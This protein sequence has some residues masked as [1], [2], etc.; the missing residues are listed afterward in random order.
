MALAAAAL[1]VA[2]PARAYHLEQKTQTISI[3]SLSDFDKC[4]KDYDSSGSE[5]CLEALRAYTKKHPREA[6]DAGKRAR[7]N[8]MHWVA[9]DFFAQALIPS[10]TRER[11]P[12]EKRAAQQRCA[13]PDVAAAVI[14]G[15]SLPPHYPAVAV[16]QKL[17]RETCWE[18]LQPAVVDELNGALSY[19]RDNT[20]AELAQKTFDTPQCKPVEPKIKSTTPSAVAQLMGVD[21]KKLSIDPSSAEALRGP[22]GEEVLLARTKPGAVPYV[23]VKFKGV[24]GPFN[25]QVLVA[26]ERNGGIGKD[27]VIAVDQS[28]WVVLTERAG[29]YQAFPRDMPEGLWVYPQR[30]SSKEA[31]KLPTRSEIAREFAAVNDPG[32]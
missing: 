22:K 14:S 31:L 26:V 17:L 21:W 24:R 11:S 28:E 8:F 12:S 7:L 9:L 2:A 25:E 4:Q 10:G 29:Q 13:D 20:C 27:Y 23:L 16:A 3:V 5:V 1:L 32:R 6:F 15:L 19:F 30:P 18:Q